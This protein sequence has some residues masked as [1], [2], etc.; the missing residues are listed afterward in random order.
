MDPHAVNA[1]AFSYKRIKANELMY[2]L[3]PPLFFR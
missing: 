3:W 2:S 1:V